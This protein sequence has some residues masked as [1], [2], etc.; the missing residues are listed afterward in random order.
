MAGNRREW[1]LEGSAGHS[2]A[3]KKKINRMSGGGITAGIGQG[4]AGQLFGHRGTTGYYEQEG[5][6]GYFEQEGAAGY[7]EQEGTTGYFGQGEIGQVQSQHL[8]GQRR[9]GYGEGGVDIFGQGG[10]GYYGQCGGCVVGQ[11]GGGAAGGAGSGY[12]RERRDVFSECTSSVGEPGG[13]SGEASGGVPRVAAGRSG[14]RRMHMYEMGPQ[15]D[16]VME[17]KRKEAIKAKKTRDKNNQQKAYY[18]QVLTNTT[19]EV[20]K[21]NME[22]NKKRMDVAELEKIVDDMSRLKP[23]PE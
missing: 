2:K 1:G 21:L 5:A 4:G 23:H 22:R 12:R 19:E 14:T 11:G 16:R 20:D 15:D 10:S 3:G 8:F 13:V 9:T 18:L 6:T 7:S 17:K